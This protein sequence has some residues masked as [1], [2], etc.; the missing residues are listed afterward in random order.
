MTA[1]RIKLGVN[2]DHIAT[3]RQARHT[4]YPDL[5]AAMRL[6]E[7]AGADTIT[8]HLREDRRHIQDA[9]V[10]DVRRLTRCGMNLEMAATDA[11]VAIAIQVRPDE[12]C[13]VPERRE[14]LTTEGGLDVI[15]QEARLREVC[16]E[17][18]RAGIRV[19]LFIEPDVAALDA[20]RRIGAPV[21]ELH[22]GAYANAT[23]PTQVAERLAAI[24]QAVE[25]GSGSGLVVNAGHGLDYDN[26]QAV[27]A[28][29][30]VHELNI[31][32][33]IV[34]RAVF[35]GI[36]AAVSEMRACIDATRA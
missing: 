8:L 27:A 13:I 25:H 14:E 26:V 29:P 4:P 9:D 7:D 18:G 31:G 3:L 22:T 20:A 36:A 15:G 21:V 2:I 5:M 19:S 17:L 12:C 24:R 6:I 35:V 30:A 23:T 34:S 32:H 1:Q 11:M 10:H 28:L 33:S 16:A